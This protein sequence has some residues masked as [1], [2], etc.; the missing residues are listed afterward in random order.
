[1]REFYSGKSIQVPSHYM[2]IDELKKWIKNNKKE[3]A[4]ARKTKTK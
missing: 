2:P 4:T 1:M 3:L